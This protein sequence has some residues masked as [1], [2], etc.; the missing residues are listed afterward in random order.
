M[1]IFFHAKSYSNVNIHKVYLHMVY[2]VFQ[3]KSTKLTTY[4]YYKFTNDYNCKI[5]NNRS[6]CVGTASAP[7]S[8]GIVMN[9]LM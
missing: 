3:Y 7:K 9:L 2:T 1:L 6:V 8:I 5:Y 4:T